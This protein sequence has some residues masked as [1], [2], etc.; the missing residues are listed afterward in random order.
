MLSLPAKQ[1]G[2]QQQSTIAGLH[3]ADTWIIKSPLRSRA[4]NVRSSEHGG[5]VFDK[6]GN[7]RYLLWRNVARTGEDK[8][9]SQAQPSIRDETL[10]LVMLNPNKA[11]ETRN[12]PTIRRCIGFAQNWGFSR[13][14]VV[15]LFAIC[16]E[17]PL[18][19]QNFKKPI[20]V[21]NDDFILDRAGHAGRI[22][23][24]WGVHGCVLARDADV[25]SKLKS[26]GPLDCFGI[27]K[28]GLPRHP[29]YVRADVR[30]STFNA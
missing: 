10:L 6:T 14:E 15:N 22:V 7:Y 8:L 25:L 30:P 26:F 17:K 3:T 13:L 12:D 27:T 21:H 11:D 18:M 19:L 23:V 20:G 2:P 24:A 9:V 4:F 29:L 1:P 28:D 5:A 16:A